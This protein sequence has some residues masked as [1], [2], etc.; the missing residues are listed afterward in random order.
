MLVFCY[1]IVSFVNKQ[2]G[3]QLAVL[4]GYTFAQKI[5]KNNLYWRCTIGNTKCKARLITTVG[6]ELKT[7]K[8]EHTHPPPKYKMVN[9][10]FVKS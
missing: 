5:Y 3:N 7:A 2:N 4:N 10:V 1:F 8:M 6:G 9:G